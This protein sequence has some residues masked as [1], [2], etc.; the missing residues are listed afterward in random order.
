MLTQEQP[1]MTT[2]SDSPYVKPLNEV[3]GEIQKQE[4]LSVR[5]KTLGIARAYLRYGHSEEAIEEI[6]RTI[7]SGDDS[8][9][10][11]LYLGEANALNGRSEIARAYYLAAELKI[12]QMLTA[13]KVGLANVEVDSEDAQNLDAETLR[14]FETLNEKTTNF[15]QEMQDK[16]QEDTWQHKIPEF[17]ILLEELRLVVTS[18]ERQFALVLGNK[19]NC[20]IL[21]QPKNKIITSNGCLFDGCLPG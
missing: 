14:V 4:D 16:L 5:S 17:Q 13:I 20:P 8:A 11:Y 21:S 7:N 19:C 18:E 15:C 10:L 2:Q 1:S 9:D 6:E 12:L 3:L